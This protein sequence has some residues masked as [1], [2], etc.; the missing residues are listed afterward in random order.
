MLDHP[1]T[2]RTKGLLRIKLGWWPRDPAVGNPGF[3]PRGRSSEALRVER[4]VARLFDL[5]LSNARVRV[6]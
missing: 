1:V 4:L 6:R 5:P 3:L 2:T